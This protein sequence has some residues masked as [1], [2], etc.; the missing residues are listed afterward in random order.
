MSRIY[1]FGAGPAVLPLPV[2]EEAQRDLLDFQGSGMSILESSHRAKEYDGVH[3]EAIANLREL[4][5]VGEEYHI[6]FLQGGAS[7]QFAMLPMN[8]LPAGAAADYIDSGHWADQAVKEA[9]RLGSVNVVADTSKE[10]PARVPALSELAF[11]AGA[12]YVHMTSNETIA[13][14]QW[15]EFPEVDAP[16]VADMS[17]D[18]LS[19]PFDTRRFAMIY[20]GAQK[21]LG[22]AGVTIV[23]IR[24]DFAEKAAQG[25]PTM[26]SYGTHIAKDSLFNTPPCFSIYIVM[27]VTRWIKRMGLAALYRQN[28]EKAARLYA[29]ID[30]SGFFRGTAVKECRSDMNVTFRLPTEDLEARFC[31]EAS[32]IGL[33]GLKG[34]RSVGGIRASIYNAFPVEGVDKLIGFMKDF[35]RKN[36]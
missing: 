26:L 2:L 29:A 4:L 16:L 21:N 7:L 23:A 10:I 18:F 9:R 15:K 3:Q 25:L 14:S 34:H 8:F 31:S 27:L 13:G 35:E 1:N 6:L 5:G 11:T 28:A 17:S 30:A 24:R 22:P 32:A 19:R 36:G 12:A 33:K 20:A